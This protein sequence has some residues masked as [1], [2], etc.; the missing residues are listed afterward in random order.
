MYL[1]VQAATAGASSEAGA[2]GERPEGGPEERPAGGD[3]G[4]ESQTPKSTNTTRQLKL[5]PAAGEPV[6]PRH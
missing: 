3:S 6:W 4:G 2:E 1:C 5:W